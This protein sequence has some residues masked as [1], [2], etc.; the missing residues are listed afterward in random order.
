V[1]LISRIAIAALIYAFWPRLTGRDAQVAERQSGR[2]A[3][4][5]HTER[6]PTPRNA[7]GNS[8]T[9]SSDQGASSKQRPVS[10]GVKATSRG[11]WSAVELV[12][13]LR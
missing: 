9:G 8:R 4:S 3:P 6:H 1:R 13:F 2:G 12:E 7:T 10:D 5:E 11:D